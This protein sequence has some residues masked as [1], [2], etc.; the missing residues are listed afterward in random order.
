MTIDVARSPAHI[1]K[2][3]DHAN[4]P[5]VEC[6]PIEQS[7]GLFKTDAGFVGAIPKLYVDTASG[8]AK[9]GS[10]Q[11]RAFCGGKEKARAKADFL[12]LAKWSGC[13]WF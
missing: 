10:P 2:S 6:V 3:S 7:D 12:P 5:L 11:N 13:S 9:K 1:R 8:R 4:R